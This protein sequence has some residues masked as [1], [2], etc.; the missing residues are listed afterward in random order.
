MPWPEAKMN[1]GTA[2]AHGVMVPAQASAIIDTPPG[3]VKKAPRLTA[4]ARPWRSSQRR[5][6]KV[7]TT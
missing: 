5:H 6:Q 3:R 7:P 1:C 4:P 2:I